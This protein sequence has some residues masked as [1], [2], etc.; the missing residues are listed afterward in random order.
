MQNKIS[1]ILYINDTKQIL[2]KSIF[3]FDIAKKTLKKHS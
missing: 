3:K 2:T 1:H